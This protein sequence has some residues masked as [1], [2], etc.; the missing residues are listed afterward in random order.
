MGGCITT[1]RRND[2]IH[3]ARNQ[4]KERDKRIYITPLC[5]GDLVAE[6]F[7]KV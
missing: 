2:P 6:L 3:A 5:L 7:K 4:R 1:Q